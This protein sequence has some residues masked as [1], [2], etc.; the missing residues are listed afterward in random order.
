M[1]GC[2][3]ELLLKIFTLAC[4]DG[5]YTGCSLSLVSRGV[6]ATSSPVKF[7]TVALRGVAS[8]CL[9]LDLLESKSPHPPTVR[10]LFLYDGDRRTDQPYA[11]QD[12]ADVAASIISTLGPSLLTLAGSLIDIRAESATIMSPQHHL[13]L[14]QDFSL[15]SIVTPSRMGTVCV[16]LPNLPN[17]RR[18]HEWVTI[19]DSDNIFDFNVLTDAAP[20]LEQIRLSGLNRSRGIPAMLDAAFK[21]IKVHWGEWDKDGHEYKLPKNIKRFIV[22]CLDTTDWNKDGR[23]KEVDIR[24]LT[25]L[26]ELATEHKQVVL[27]PVLQ[28]Y[29]IQDNWEDWLDVIEGGDGCWRIP[30][31]I[32]SNEKRM[33]IDTYVD[34]P[35]DFF[36]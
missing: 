23:L 21:G 19:Y 7:H 15:M 6:H 29:T 26:S 31:K 13:P 24:M 18:L 5:G 27:V 4:T 3:T 20:N 8:M 2:P 10:H 35:D 12:Q 34:L 17:L 16:A 33:R 28:R 30:P 22:S 1:D 32:T 14:L 9:F 36:D 25:R 11:G